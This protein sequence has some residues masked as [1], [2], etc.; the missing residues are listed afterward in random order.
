MVSK[1]DFP[2]LPGSYPQVEDLAENSEDECAIE[3]L[4]RQ[5]HSRNSKQ[6]SRNKI[7]LNDVDMDQN[8]RHKPY[9]NKFEQ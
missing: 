4:R 2:Y 1:E 6:K 7:A 8:T 5:N 3:D 9:K